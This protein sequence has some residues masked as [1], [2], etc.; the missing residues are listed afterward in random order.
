MR[1]LPIGVFDSGV[2]GLTVVKEILKELPNESIV[3]L[4]DTARV[5]YGT[6]DE[7]TIKKF[8]KE[9]AE[10]MIKKNVKAIVVA[11]NTISAVALDDIR[12]IAG[13]I[14]IIDVIGPTAEIAAKSTY[15]SVLGVIGTRATTHSRAFQ[16][17]ISRHGEGFKVIS[18]ACPLFVP[19]V[20]GGVIFQKSNEKIA[21]RYLE[22]INNSAADVLILGCTHYPNAY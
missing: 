14:P 17:Q 19:I 5:P 6:R 12:K 8:S 21:E 10:Y 15:T 22:E 1:N 2:G 9:L 4:G 11:C 13:N 3:Y 20:E 16:A 18:I 7:S